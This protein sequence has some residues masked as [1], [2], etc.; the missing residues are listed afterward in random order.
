MQR[1]NDL[2]VQ[3]LMQRRNDLDVQELIQKKNWGGEEL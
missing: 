1:R 3:E 2:D